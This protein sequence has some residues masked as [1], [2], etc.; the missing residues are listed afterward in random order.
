MKTISTIAIILICHLSF[1]QISDSN[2]IKQ[3]FTNI[4]LA[5][6]DPA[7][8][9][10]L[11]LSDQTL[12]LD[13][14]NWS[15]FIN[16][17]YLSLKNDHLKELPKEIMLLSKLKTLELSG[18]D[19]SV[20]PEDFWKLRSLEELFLND[21]KNLNLEANIKIMSK[22]PSLRILHLENDNL[23]SIPSTISSLKNIEFLYLNNNQFKEI[24]KEIKQLEHLQFLDMQDNKIINPDRSGENLNFGF[25][26]KL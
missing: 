10:R 9:F 6:K 8:V 3:E 22:M 2:K 5:L 4:E 20:L 19:F 1:G 17:E 24:P 7:N 14:V 12:N 15:K 26:I 18:N 13:G 11:N 21:E 16:L 23:K 25:R